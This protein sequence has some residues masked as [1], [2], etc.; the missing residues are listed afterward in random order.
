MDQVQEKLLVFRSKLDQI[1][2]LQQAEVRNELEQRKEGGSG[3]FCG[4]CD[5]SWIVF[6]LKLYPL[7]R[8]GLTYPFCRVCKYWRLLPRSPRNT[9]FLVEDL[10]SFWWSFLELEPESY[11]VSLALFTLPSSPFSPLKIKTEEMMSSGLF[12]GSSFPFL[13]SLRPLPTFWFTGFPFI[14]HSNWPFCCGL[15]F[16]KQRGPSSCTTPF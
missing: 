2:A 15:C 11:A 8:H 13:L 7:T 5:V 10:S 9:L 14:M 12:T 3:T 1:P 6:R 4:N 16:H